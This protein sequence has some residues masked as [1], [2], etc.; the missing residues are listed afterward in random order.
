VGGERELQANFLGSVEYV[1]NA[2]GTDDRFLDDL[3]H[4]VLGRDPDDTGRSGWGGSLCSKTARCLIRARIDCLS[5]T[6]ISIG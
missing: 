1:Q 5:N 4:D 6:P 3:Y 2:G